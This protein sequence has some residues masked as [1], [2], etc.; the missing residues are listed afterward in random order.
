MKDDEKKRCRELLQNSKAYERTKFEATL[1]APKSEIKA[2]FDYLDENV[3]DCD[4]TLRQT[5]E[6]VRERNLPEEPII[7]R[8]NKHGG[9][10]DCEVLAN[11]EDEYS[12]MFGE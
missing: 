5:V 4:D 7:S 2:L 3:E 10:C 1:P 9:F 11:V 8:L 6:F 12:Q